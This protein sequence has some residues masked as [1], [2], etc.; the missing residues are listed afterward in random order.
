VPGM[1][2]LILMLFPAILGAL[3]VVREKESGTIFNLYASPV[4]RWEII[5]GKAVPYI[6]VAF[7][8]YLIIFAMSIFLFQVRFTGSFWVLSSAALLYSIC[9]IGI[10]L[11][12]SIIMRTQLSAM[13]ITFL[14]TVTPAFNYSGF[15]SPVSSMD[16]LGQFIAHLIPATYFMEVVRGVYLKGLGLGFFWPNLLALTI[17]TLV[18]YTLAWSLLIKRIR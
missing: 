8:D 7:L 6:T 18:V 14:A 13:L 12:F 1:M 11:L 10:G 17:Y 3:V 2:V 16:Q 5:L 4:Y 9:T 15:L